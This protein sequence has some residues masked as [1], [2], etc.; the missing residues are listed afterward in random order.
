[1][2][3]WVENPPTVADLMGWSG[4]PREPD[5]VPLSEINKFPEFIPYDDADRKRIED[6]NRGGSEST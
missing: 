5:Y 4:T 1:M 2:A 3:A 6:Q